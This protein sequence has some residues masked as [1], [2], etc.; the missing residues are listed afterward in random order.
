MEITVKRSILAVIAGVVFIVVVT[1]L[2]D[3]ALH[4]AK[5]YPPMDEPMDNAR[6][7][8][9]TSYRVVISTLGAWLTAKLAPR[10]PMKHAMALGYVGTVLALVGV[11]VVW[12]K[13]LAPMWYPM[14]LV[15]LAIPP[16]WAGGWIHERLSVKGVHP[17]TAG[18]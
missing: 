5:V 18:A 3:V 14:A 10:N 13:G 6:S 15:V 16:C 11:A 1:T 7:V 8:L 12:N 9:A 2:V 17:G 4:L